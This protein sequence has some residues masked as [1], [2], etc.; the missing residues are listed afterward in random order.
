MLIEQLGK[1]IVC[2][3]LDTESTTTSQAEQ[4]YKR[5]ALTENCFIKMQNNIIDN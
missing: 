2:T 3:Y 5:R 1:S 4:I